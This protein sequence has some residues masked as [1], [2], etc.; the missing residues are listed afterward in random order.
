MMI[1]KPLGEIGR[2][3]YRSLECICN[4]FLPLN[5][6]GTR[7]SRH[8]TKARV[9]WRKADMAGV[10]IVF[11]FPSPPENNERW[12]TRRVEAKTWERK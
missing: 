6:D 10:F 11:F 2:D 5:M 12:M 8:R 9:A 1:D 4:S 7:K 3:D